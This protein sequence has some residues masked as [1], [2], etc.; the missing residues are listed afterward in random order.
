MS[1]TR[2]F[3]LPGRKRG[4]QEEVNSKKL[5]PLNQECFSAAISYSLARPNRYCVPSRQP[6]GCLMPVQ[7]SDYPLD[8]D[9]QNACQWALW[10]L[11]KST[12]NPALK[13]L[14]NQWCNVTGVKGE[15]PI[16][17]RN[18]TKIIKGTGR[19]NGLVLYSLEKWRLN[20]DK[21]QVYK[22]RDREGRERRPYLPFSQLQEFVATRYMQKAQSLKILPEI[23]GC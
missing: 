16:C 2:I 3:S 8:R 19:L 17:K 21:I 5:H 7:E 11:S 14:S 22:I 12:Y 13:H 15:P 9:E 4:N 23:P 10:F 18:R 20:G 1:N 6:E